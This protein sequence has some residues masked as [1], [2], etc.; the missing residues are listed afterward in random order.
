[1][2]DEIVIRIPYSVLR[3]LLA[4]QDHAA[5]AQQ[6]AFEE[7]VENR[8]WSDKQKRFLYR[9]LQRLEYE[10]DA[11]KNYITTALRLN[12][13]PPTRGQASQLIDR[14]QAELGRGGH[15]VRRG[16]A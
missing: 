12:G 4:T 8:P 2:N 6:P 15:E 9:L 5:D 10:G 13:E 16:A 14:L 3:E 11:A 1:M 7:S